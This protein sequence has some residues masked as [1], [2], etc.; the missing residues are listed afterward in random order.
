ME[1]PELNIEKNL[2]FLNWLDF[3]TKDKNTYIDEL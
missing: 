1:L 3:V 2:R